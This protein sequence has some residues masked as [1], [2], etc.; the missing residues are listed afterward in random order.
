MQFNES[1][2]A[3]ICFPSSTFNLCF[4][5]NAIN[6]TQFVINETSAQQFDWNPKDNEIV[7]FAVFVDENGSN[8]D[9]EANGKYDGSPD[10]ESTTVAHQEMKI[11][12]AIETFESF[13]GKVW[14]IIGDDCWT[15]NQ[16]KFKPN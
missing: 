9:A 1:S 3:V 14:S 2:R 13:L 6:C 4:D 5:E 16:K 7:T 10:D 12:Q 8:D 11:K 15:T